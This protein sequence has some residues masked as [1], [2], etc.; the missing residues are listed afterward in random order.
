MV[1]HAKGPNQSRRRLPPSHGQSFDCVPV[2]RVSLTALVSA[3][4][5]G[6]PGGIVELIL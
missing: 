4:V 3:L 6:F 2:F 5:H 1:W